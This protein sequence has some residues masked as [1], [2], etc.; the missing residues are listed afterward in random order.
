MP[1]ARSCP[2]PRACRAKFLS[3]WCRAPRRLRGAQD[4]MAGGDGSVYVLT[5]TDFVLLALLAFV[6]CT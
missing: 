6:A 5:Q 3:H 2:L 1:L 4:R